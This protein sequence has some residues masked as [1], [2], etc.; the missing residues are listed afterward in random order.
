MFLRTCH[1][2]HAVTWHVSDMY[3]HACSLVGYMCK[4]FSVVFVGAE[5]YLSSESLVI[6]L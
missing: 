1:I 6:G 2:V 4:Q 3:V 5:L